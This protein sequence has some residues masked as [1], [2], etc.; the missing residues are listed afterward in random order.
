MRIRINLLFAAFI[1]F[2]SVS[3]TTAQTP[4]STGSNATDGDYKITSTIEAGARGLSVNGDHEKYRSDLNY[5]AG[6]R[7][8][9]SSVLIEKES[10]GP[11]TFFNSALVQGSGWGADP[12]GFFRLN[13]ERVGS[14]KLDTNIRRVRY[15][16]DL[17]NHV[18]AWSQVVPTGSQHDMNTLHHFGDIDVVIFPERENFRMRFGTSFNDTSGPGSYTLRFPRSS[19]DEFEVGSSIDYMSRDLRAGV[20]GKLLG[21]NLGLNYGHRWFRDDTSYF[22]DAFNLGNNPAANNAILT[23]AV[24][25]F[26]T[27]GNTDYANFFFQRTF[28]GRFDLAGRVTHSVSTSRINQNDALT[29]RVSTTGNIIVAD[30]IFVPGHTKR[31]QTRADLGLTYMATKNFRISNTFTFDQFNISGSNEFLE[32]D[33]RTTAAG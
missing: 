30:N 18:N 15:F 8:F 29:G 26:R 6:F 28:G 32:I 22:E 21:F 12:S 9:D 17:K 4:Q 1:A 23:S 25:N 31:P 20:E 19:S 7:V 24:R 11:M 10:S 2:V 33:R 14:F 5:R 16:N 27:R 3:I 13:M